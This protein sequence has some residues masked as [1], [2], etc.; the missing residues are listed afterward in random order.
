MRTLVIGAYGHFGKIICQK[1]LG[2]NGVQVIP[3]GRKRDQLE[4]LCTSLSITSDNDDAPYLV[5]DARSSDLAKTLSDKNIHLVINATGPFQSQDYTV[6]KACIEAQCYYADIA[7]DGN[8]V[9]NSHKLHDSAEKANVM[10]AMGLGLSVVNMAILDRVA[11]HFSRMEHISIGYSGS[12]RMPG[13]A[14]IKSVLS[15]AGQPVEQIEGKRPMEFR[16]LLGRNYRFFDNGFIKRDL[17]TMSSPDIPLVKAWYNP[18]TLRYQGGFGLRGQR[19][20][21]FISQFAKYRWIKDPQKWAKFLQRMGRMMSSFS[22]GRGALFIDIEG[23]KD[24]KD[25]SMTFEIQATDNQFEFLKVVPIIVLVRRLM[26]NY[27]PQSGSRPGI[28]LMSFD[29]IEKELDPD[30]FTIIEKPLT[31]G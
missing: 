10:V 25:V 20:I 28:D 18:L 21:S 1:L 15:Y 13:L 6:A 29:D 11:K 14:S 23:K 24:R 9:F 31:E 26:D 12:G 22:G 5:L 19:V 30:F 17:L 4:A 16:G 7:D 2:I 27:V 3:C 8:F